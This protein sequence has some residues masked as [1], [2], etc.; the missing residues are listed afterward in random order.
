MRTPRLR[1]VK[2]LGGGLRARGREPQYEPR[3]VGFQSPAFS[4]GPCLILQSQDSPV[5]LT[6]QTKSITFVTLAISLASQIT[7]TNHMSPDRAEG[8]CRGIGH[9]R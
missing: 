6:G 3:S 8:N 2:E 9:R 5:S 1:G 7:G 4:V